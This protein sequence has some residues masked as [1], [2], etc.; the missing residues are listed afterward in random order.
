M[1]RSSDVVIDAGVGVYQVVHGTLSVQIYNKWTQWIEEDCSVHAP[2]FWLNETTSVMHKMYKQ[3]LLEHDM[4][5]EALDA[6]LGLGVVLHQAEAETCRRA[7]T[8][9]DRL[10][11]HAAYDSFYL[12]LAEELQTEF[13][14]TDKRLVNRARQ[15]G[16]DWVC[17]VGEQ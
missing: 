14:T 15:L 17:W 5:R 10:D 7:F 4:A 11:Q 8:W 12:A 3:K 13:W 16:V 1:T 9:A 2:R 6:V